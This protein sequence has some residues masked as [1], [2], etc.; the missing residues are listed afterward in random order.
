MKKYDSLIDAILDMRSQGYKEDF[1]LNFDKIESENGKFSFMHNQFKVDQLIRIDVDND[2]GEQAI[3][4][5]IS[6]GNGE[7]KGLLVMAFD[8]FK[9]EMTDGMLKKMSH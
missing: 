5:A 7:V 4:Y 8:Q 6:S 1:N 9:D 3:V 2:S